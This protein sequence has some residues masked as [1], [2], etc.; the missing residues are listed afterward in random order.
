MADEL[1]SALDLAM[2]KLDKEMG[3][4][5]PSLSDEQKDR[6]AEVR[7]KFRAK[8]AEAEIAAQSDIKK[9]RQSGDQQSINDVQDRLVR[10]KKRLE[11][12]SERQ[13]QK[14]RSE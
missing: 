9:I 3:G 1:K 2:E 13:V 12:E 4:S 5:L 11:A 14:I 8:I 10:E 7:S 6:I